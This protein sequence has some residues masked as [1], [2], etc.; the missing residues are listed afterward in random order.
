MARTY[1]VIKAEI[2]TQIRTY[3][4]MNNFLFPEEGGS[5]VAV[6]NLIIASV[7]QCILTFEVLIDV[8]KTAL[9]S[10]A[11]TAQAGN[12]KWLQKQILAFQY[13]DI[14]TFVN[15]VPAYNPI[16]P[17]HLLVTQ[18]S[19]KDLGNGSVAVKVA[20]GISPSLIP[21]SAPELAA[22]KDYYFGTSTAQGIGFAGV[23]IS[24]VNADA[25]R[26]RI[27]AV[28]Y[29][30]GQYTQATVSAAVI[31]AINNFLST[32]STVAFDGTIFMIKMVDAIQAVPGVSRVS[33]TD[34]KARPS[35]VPLG[36]A[37]P[38]DIQGYYLTYAGYVIT[39]DTAANTLT[40]TL[41]FTQETA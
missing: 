21:L 1:E 2:Q 31:V 28:I 40:D 26:I 11:N 27:Q 32:F 35:T 41:T 37:S 30:L 17:T 6:H 7:A 25:D 10:I 36:S 13:G 14:I 3:P 8:A 12:A 38:V 39:E 18:C 24:F 19:V 5:A 29:F 23:K 15:N 34:I 16:D 9:Q 20:K 4:S 22:L 33:L